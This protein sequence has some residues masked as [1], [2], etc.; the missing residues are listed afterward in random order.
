MNFNSNDLNDNAPVG[1]DGII[2]EHTK[3][4]SYIN[5]NS[6]R[7]ALVLWLLITGGVTAYF[8]LSHELWTVYFFLLQAIDG[9]V[10]FLTSDKLR[11]SR[12]MMIY[13]FVAALF[14][15]GLLGL[16]MTFPKYFENMS[17]H[18]ISNCVCAVIAASGAGMLVYGV[19]H[20]RKMKRH[21]TVP[22]EG[23][24]LRLMIFHKR[25]HPHYNPVFRFSFNGNRYEGSEY[26]HYRGRVPE[27]GDRLRIFIDPED[28][29]TIR[30]PKRA[31]RE[32]QTSVT[33][34][35]LLFLAGLA[36]MLLGAVA[37]FGFFEH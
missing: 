23:T 16:R 14:S 9:A 27:V 22:I 36:L 12:N 19:V 17:G 32:L 25:R 4:N 34:G 35:F 1:D 26:K 21:C 24:V 5:P 28:P 11:R 10:L 3:R 13:M 33:Y 15:V 2:R 20:D 7:L 31:K 29:V 6:G 18:F 8:S 37:N 30:E